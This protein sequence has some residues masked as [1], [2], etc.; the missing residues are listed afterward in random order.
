[1][2]GNYVHIR[3]VV[4]KTALSEATFERWPSL[5][6]AKKK[7]GLYN[8]LHMLYYNHGKVF[9]PYRTNV[10]LK[11]LLMVSSISI[12]TNESYYYALSR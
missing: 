1:M 6:V 3:E 12:L 4:A 5:V 7:R 2:F 8:Y 9:K 10:L 11:R